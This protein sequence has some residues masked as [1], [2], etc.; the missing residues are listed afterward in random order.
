MQEEKGRRNN[1]PDTK[2]S[3]LIML[4]YDDNYVADNV[5]TATMKISQ[6]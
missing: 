3:S 6:I 5:I 1:L 2:E 4:Y